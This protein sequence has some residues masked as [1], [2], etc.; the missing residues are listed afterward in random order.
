MHGTCTGSMQAQGREG[1]STMCFIAV[2]MQTCGVMNARNWYRFQ[3]SMRSDECMALVQVSMQ[4]QGRKGSSFQVQGCEGSSPTCFIVSL[5]SH[6]G[7]GRHT[8]LWREEVD[9]VIPVLTKLWGEGAM[10]ASLQWSPWPCQDFSVGALGMRDEALLETVANGILAEHQW[11]R[12]CCFA[13]GMEEMMEEVLSRNWRGREDAKGALELLASKLL[14][15]IN[16]I[17]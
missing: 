6:T 3:T 15:Q 8:S 11:C 1:P 10:H 16:G 17:A 13:V 12:R 14:P 2:D 4:A 7:G 9:G 5:C